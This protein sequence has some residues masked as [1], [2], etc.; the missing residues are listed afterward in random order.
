MNFVESIF[1]LKSFEVYK[2]SYIQLHMKKLLGAI[3]GSHY[4][5]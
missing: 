4:F 2:N 1:R 3:K 5:D